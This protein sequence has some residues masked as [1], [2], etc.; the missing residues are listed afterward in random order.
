MQQGIDLK[1][2]RKKELGNIY[3]I[4]IVDGQLELTDN[5]DTNL[6]MSVYCERRADSSEVLLPQQR[7]GWWGN[8]LSET[9]G[10]EIGSK[11]WLLQQARLT[12][13]TLNKAIA[14]TQEALDWFVEHKLLK[15]VQVEA[16]L[17]GNSGIRLTIKL[18]RFSDEVETRFFD[19]WS[20]TTSPDKRSL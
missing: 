9:V 17:N 1:L 13:D 19:L 4:S 16:S 5:F 15:R 10:F 12:K 14:Y 6:Q 7:R 11:L 2:T 3:D 18:T 20:N 8:E